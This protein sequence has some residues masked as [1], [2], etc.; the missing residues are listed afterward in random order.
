MEKC[1]VAKADH[2]LEW[3]VTVKGVEFLLNYAPSTDYAMVVVGNG[4][5]LVGYTYECVSP[6]PFGY[7]IERIR[8]TLSTVLIDVQNE[9][10]TEKG[11]EKVL[12]E[13]MKLI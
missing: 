1:S 3:Y 10:Y 11:A 4:S 9:F 2:R 5:I 6:T 12:L 7:C 13:Q 8:P